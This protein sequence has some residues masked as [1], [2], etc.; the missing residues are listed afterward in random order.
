MPYHGPADGVFEGGGVKG[1]AL[2]GALEVAERYVTRWES[3][4]GTSGGAIVAALLAAKYTPRDILAFLTGESLPGV[5][6]KF[7]LRD[8]PKRRAL[9]GVKVISQAVN[10]LGYLGLYS[11]DYFEEMMTAVL[12]AGP[13]PVTTFGA[14][15]AAEADVAEGHPPYRLQ[16]IATD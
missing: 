6:G 12:A 15:R 14:L 1:I 8:L 7:R 4:A 10:L 3:L 9:G 16:F 2:V 5:P 13:E 11:G